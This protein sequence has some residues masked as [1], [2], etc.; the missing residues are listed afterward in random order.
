[1]ALS[2]YL[3]FKDEARKAIEF[4]E[5][6]FETEITSILTYGEMPQDENFPITEEVKNL[7]AN[8]A[9]EIH[10]TRLMFSDVPDGMGFE[11]KEGN[12]ISITVLSNNKDLIKKQFIALSKNGTVDMPLDV[13]FW[14]PLYGSL[15]DQFGINWQFNFEE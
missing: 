8:A 12:N 5:Q 6:A 2:I 1:M 15:I 3:N 4:Y 11:L 7:I 13:T 10:G 9:M 14:S